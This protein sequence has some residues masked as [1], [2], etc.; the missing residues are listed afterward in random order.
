MAS[1]RTSRIASLLRKRHRGCRLLEVALEMSE[2]VVSDIYESGI[3]D[4]EERQGGQG[5]HTFAAA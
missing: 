1:L 5:P 3:D 2:V 4:I